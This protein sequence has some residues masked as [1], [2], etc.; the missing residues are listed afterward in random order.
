M[1]VFRPAHHSQ[2]HRRLRAGQHRAVQR[3]LRL[4]LLAQPV[5]RQ[6]IPQSRISPVGAKILGY[7]PQET[8]AGQL[9][10]NY[11][12]S[13][14][15]RYY[16]NQPMARFDHVFGLNDKLYGMFTF[17]DGYEYRAN[18][19][20]PGAAPGNVDNKRTF[21]N[22]I[23][24]YTR[25]MNATTVFDVRSSYYRF[26]QKTPGYN[27]QALQLGAA[28]DFGMTKMVIPPTVPWRHRSRLHRWAATA[29]SSATAPRLE[30]GPRRPRGTLRP[31]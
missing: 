18:F 19:P 12:S 10:Q 16:Y 14:T 1:T 21:T 4:H 3:Q 6:H 5:P 24:N 30:P 2:L 27:D 11:V 13:N 26:V 25:V 7:Y 20:K 28:K 23:V 15:G 17:Q 22:V 9:L 31:A 29:R 8:V